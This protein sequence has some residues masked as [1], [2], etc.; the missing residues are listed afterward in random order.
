VVI[1][2]GA[3]ALLHGG[4]HEGNPLQAVLS[5]QVLFVGNQRA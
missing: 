3:P 1:A 4:Y 2:A 5:A